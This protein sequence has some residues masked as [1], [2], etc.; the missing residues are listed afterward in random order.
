M[1]LLVGLIVAVSFRVQFQLFLS[2]FYSQYYP[3]VQQL[4]SRSLGIASC[5]S[6]LHKR[7]VAEAGVLVDSEFLEMESFR[8]TE[9][10]KRVRFSTD[11]SS[12]WN[13]R[14]QRMEIDGIGL[15][16]V[17]RMLTKRVAVILIHHQKKEGILEGQNSGC[18]RRERE[19][20]S[21]SPNWSSNDSGS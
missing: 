6:T 15:I 10:Q 4:L 11:Y 2:T 16:S 9:I 17:L 14:K 18:W 12:I 3:S 1:V 5:C 19:Q 8:P 21:W 20:T 13:G 7:V